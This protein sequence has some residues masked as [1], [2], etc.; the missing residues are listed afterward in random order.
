MSLP[1]IKRSEI[2]EP[3]KAL[4]EQYES[5]QANQRGRTEPNQNLTWQEFGA[6]L[7]ARREAALALR[8][9]LVPAE[10]REEFDAELFYRDMQRLRDARK[11]ISEIPGVVK[12]S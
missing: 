3:V 6:R 12:I 4:V 5:N 8:D 10:L 1:K 11:K 9:E 7:R 2:S